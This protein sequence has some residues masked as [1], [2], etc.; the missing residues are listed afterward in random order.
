[1]SEFKARSAREGVSVLHCRTCGKQLYGLNDI[2]KRLRELP[3]RLE[4]LRIKADDEAANRPKQEPAPQPVQTPNQPKAEPRL[5][6]VP[7]SVPGRSSTASKH[8][9]SS[10]RMRS[11]A[12]SNRLENLSKK[13]LSS[14]SRSRDSFMALAYAN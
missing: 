11:S 2:R 8:S 9:S 13:W 5:D 4:T 1:M 10:P 12:S 14:S 3:V 6:T 7:R